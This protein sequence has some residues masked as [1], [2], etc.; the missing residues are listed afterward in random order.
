LT[1]KARGVIPEHYPADD[2]IYVTELYSIENYLVCE[3]VVNHVFCDFVVLKKCTLPKDKVIKRFAS[4]LPRFQR[5]LTPIMAW[6]I[7]VRRKAISVSLQNLDLAEMFSLDPDLRIR[8]MNGTIPYLAGKT[9]V[10]NT[11]ALW[12]DLKSVIRMLKPMNPKRFVRGK[13]ESWFLLRF[14]KAAVDQLQSAAQAIK[15]DIEVS[16]RVERSNMIPLLAPYGAKPSSL[17]AFVAS[18]LGTMTSPKK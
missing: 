4:E 5:L 13:F 17:D 14:V 10:A 12:A 15:G 1:S 2:R 18:K 16:V 7:C 9:G 11:P 6:T 8:R 3:E